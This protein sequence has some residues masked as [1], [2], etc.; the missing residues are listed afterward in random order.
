MERKVSD[1]VSISKFLFWK[2]RNGEIAFLV[3]S[4]FLNTSYLYQSHYCNPR[5]VPKMSFLVLG[6][7]WSLCC[8]TRHASSPRPLLCLIVSFLLTDQD[9]CDDGNEGFRAE[10]AHHY[11]QHPSPQDYIHGGWSSN[12]SRHE[13][14]Y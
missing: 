6:G 13:Q 9:R 10:R 8:A 3:R 1:N 7:R 12:N 14:L 4:N 5:F 2:E 11:S